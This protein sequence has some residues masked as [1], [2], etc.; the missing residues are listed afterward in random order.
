MAFIFL[1]VHFVLVKIFLDETVRDRES[2]FEDYLLVNN[3]RP[4]RDEKS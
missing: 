3:K 1:F 2:V 4:E